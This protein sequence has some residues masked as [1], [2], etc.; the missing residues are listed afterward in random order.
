MSERSL[1]TCEVAAYLHVNPKQVYRLIRD[2]DLPCRWVTGRWVFCQNLVDHW[3]Y[4]HIQHRN[5]RVL[6]ATENRK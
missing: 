2:K 4:S 6:E 1:T 3:V 5:V